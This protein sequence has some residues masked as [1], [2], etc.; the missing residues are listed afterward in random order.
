MTWEG[1]EI[2]A[3]PDGGREF[4][5]ADPA[6]SYIRID[7]QSRLHFGKAELAIECPFTLQVGDTVHQLDPQDRASIGPL[8]TLYPDTITQLL[9]S[10]GGTLRAT[11]A[12]GALLTVEPHP[13]FEAWNICGFWCSPGGFED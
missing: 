10:S 2:R 9:M 8:L 6:L 5:L 11:F 12:S 1:C 7:G 4:L 13:R 3:Q